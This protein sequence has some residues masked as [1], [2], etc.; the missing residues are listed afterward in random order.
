VENR[1]GR[2]ALWSFFKDDLSDDSI[3]VKPIDLSKLKNVAP[4]N[5]VVYMQE[6]EVLD[7]LQ[8]PNREEYLQTL[9]PKPI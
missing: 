1:L 9:I 8:T 3:K 4:T 5:V 2:F 6:G 7:I